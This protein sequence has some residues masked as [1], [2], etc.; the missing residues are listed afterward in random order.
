MQMKI[1]KLQSSHE[2]MRQSS[3][4]QHVSGSVEAR[5][6]ALE[7]SY[8]LAQ[9]Q[10]GMALATAEQLKTSDLPA[11]VLS[12]HT[13]MKARL[14]EMQQA[15]VSLEQLSQLQSMLKGKNEEFEGVRIQVE[16]LASLSGELSQKVEVLTG[17]LGE[18][19]LKLDE[20][21]GQFATL[22]AT[23]DGQAA[24]VLRLKE[25]LGA[26]QAQLEASMLEMTTVRELLKNEQ[27]Q[28]LQQ[29]SVEEQLDTVRQS[30]Q[31]Q[32]SAAQSLHSELGAQLESIQKEVTQANC[33]RVAHLGYLVDMEAEEE[34]KAEEEE[35]AAALDDSVTEQTEDGE[36]VT[37]DE[38][39]QEESADVSE[40]E[41]EDTAQTEE[42]EQN[43]KE[44][45]PE[46]KNQVAD[47]EA[48]LDGEEV[49]EE[50]HK[51]EEEKEEAAEEEDDE[52]EEETASEAEEEQP[53][54]EEEVLEGEE[55]QQDVAAEEEPQE[56]ED[57]A[58]EDDALPEDK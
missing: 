13:E 19:E 15:T 23:V 47:E 16:G 3:N 45:T 30:L 43:V 48:G 12:L 44:E 11:Q 32:N 37:E 22:S 7:E 41:E 18:A 29:A 42:E 26:H 50:S 38:P 53:N 1:V 57:E 10:V 40:K 4:K 34:E 5:L 17:S 24:E 49:Q 36:A 20:R 56:E 2:E 8:A 51:A 9:K 58:I 21:A 6:N 39:E 28:Q 55:E 14:A 33:T 25:Q 46:E 54:V 27:S 35:E 31:D 52:T